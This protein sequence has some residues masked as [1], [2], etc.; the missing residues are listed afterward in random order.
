MFVELL[1]V[2]LK[3]L[4]WFYFDGRCCCFVLCVVVRLRTCV[5]FVRLD[6]FN[7]WG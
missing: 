5:G 1:F 6:G 3:F 7:L 4:V 2:V